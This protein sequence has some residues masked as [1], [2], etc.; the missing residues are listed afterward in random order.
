MI[1][2][3]VLAPEQ[4]PDILPGAGLPKLIADSL[5]DCA[6]Q[7]GDIVVITHKIVSKAEGAVV[8]L[9]SV[10]PGEKAIH[11]A[12]ACDKDPRLVQII[13]NE[14]DAILSYEH[15]PIICRHKR[16]YICAN[17]AVDL[18]NSIPGHAVLLPKDPDASASM[19]RKALEEKFRA[20][21]GVIICDT[22][23]RAFRL[24][25]CG[26]SVGASGVV[27]QKSYIEKMDRV[28]RVMK[29]SVECVL[30]ELASAATIVM[31]QGD[32]GRP[33][34][35][36]RGCGDLL[37]VGSASDIIRPAEKDLFLKAFEGNSHEKNGQRESKSLPSQG[38]AVKGMVTIALAGA[39]AYV[40]ARFT[41][42]P[43]FPSA[44]FLKLDFGETPLIL[45]SLFSVKY[46]LTA[47]LMKEMLSFA[48]SGSEILGLIADFAAC[49]TFIS[50][51]GLMARGKISA[52]KMAFAACIGSIARCVVV[53]P[54]NLVILRLQFGTDAPA[55]IAQLP[56][57]MV[58][59]LLKSGLGSV[60]AIFL[61]PKLK[62]HYLALSGILQIVFI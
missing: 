45:L 56:L 29:S 51:F 54:V 10:T 49:G 37:G 7:E 55:V 18:S 5:K 14:S 44:A 59:N 1:G 43:I 23:G 36:I 11:I 21:L 16:G 42:F 38:M 60:C 34:A 31:G 3:S 62:R 6:P 41:K 46:G 26:V 27:S 13:I 15:G 8:K 57:I 2:Y 17:A 48:V 12:A 20:R 40:L 61:F 50:I 22:H 19:I 39:V 28:G 58:F 4:F 24:H 33:V 30:D 35:V 25:A 47:L 52:R 9:D 53:I 32:E